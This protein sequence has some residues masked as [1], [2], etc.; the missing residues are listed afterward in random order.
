MFGMGSPKKPSSCANAVVTGAGSGIGRAFALEIANRGGAVLCS[1]INL[2]AAEETAGQITASGGQARACQCDVSDLGQ[3]EALAKA[4]DEHLPGDVDLVINNA[5]VGIG[6]LPIGETAIEDWHWTL[7]INLW[8]V[9]HGCHVFAPRLR[10][11]G[12]G[13]LVNVASTASFSAA[14]LMGPYNV[15]KAGALALTET[16]AAELAGSG[17][18]VTALCPTLVKTNINANGRIVGDSSKLFDRLMNR[19]GMSAE[20]VVND[21]LN[22]LDRGDLYV[23]P[24]F[25]ARLIWRAK[26]LIPRTYALGTG[27][28]NRFGA[29]RLN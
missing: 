14:P 20:R 10:K 17:V 7:G 24:Q 13:G 9:I 26:R 22:A 28:I 2:A 16:L 1:D 18:A 5:G 25:D 15:T 23:M 8:G 12:R 19:F 3:V 29:S 4:A 11:L 6:G 21:A 27:L